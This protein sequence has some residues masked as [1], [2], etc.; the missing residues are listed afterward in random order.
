MIKRLIVLS[1]IYIFSSCATEY[2]RKDITKN[3]ERY[4][5]EQ[6]FERAYTEFE[7]SVSEHYEDIELHRDFIRFVSKAHRCLDANRF[8]EDNRK[9]KGYEHI[10]YYAKGLLGVVCI[11]MEKKDVM[12]N[13]SKAIEFAPD[14]FE[15]RLR[16]G[17]ILTEYEMYNEA[18]RQFE[19]LYKL[20]PASSAVMSYLA[21]CSASLGSFEKG[22]QYIQKMMDLDFSD[23]DLA[24]ANRA[25]D[26]INSSCLDTPSE[27]RDSF[28][29]IL[30]MI[31][32]EDRPAQAR[33]I[34]ENLILKYANIPALRLIKSM[35]LSLTGEFSAALYE[36]NSMGNISNECSYFQY[37]GGIIYLGVQKEDKGIT[38][39]EKAIELDPLMINSYRIL[40][41]LYIS[42]KDNPKAERALRYYLKL[43]RDDHKSRFL[44][45]RLLLWEKKF[46]EASKQFETI[47]A[48]EPEN[49]LGI[50][51]MGMLY[52]EYARASKDRRE[53]DI[54][55]K[56]SLEYLNTAIKKDPENETIKSIIKSLNIKEE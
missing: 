35:A 4:L 1:I 29:K 36:L 52:A 28:K 22:R 37:T 11:E 50:V 6:R 20:N 53:R 23:A 46:D 15:I 48:M 13:F 55:L 16:Y 18:S 5:S 38:M 56:R 19:A 34:I 32:I 12:E 41:E 54:N 49:S 17:S 10:Y 2:N 30:D 27:I 43:K 33:E 39:L 45:G 14:N 31:L 21:L 40:S 44:Y 42:R 26:I 8:Y 24:R 9:K 3:A 25:M 51:G 7:S 47:L